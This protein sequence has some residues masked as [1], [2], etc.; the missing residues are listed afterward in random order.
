[1]KL[2]S[3]SH[4][5]KHLTKLPDAVAKRIYNKLNNLVQNAA[6]I[7]VK[8]LQG[9]NDYRLRLGSYRIIFEYRSISG[10]VVILL[11]HVEQRKDVYRKRKK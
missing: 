3:T 4:F 1:M 10:E 6:N 5:E 7:D 2:I 9:G 8:K 11:K